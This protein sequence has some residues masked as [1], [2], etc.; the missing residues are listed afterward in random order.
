ML[1][2]D[3][4][5][6]NNTRWAIGGCPADPQWTPCACV[7]GPLGSGPRAYAKP[8]DSD[9]VERVEFKPG[10]Q[11]ARHQRKGGTS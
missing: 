5:L 7:G 10:N 1:R 9:E 3:C 11:R 2:P 6:C 8:G 4:S